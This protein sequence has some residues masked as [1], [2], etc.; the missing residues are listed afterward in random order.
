[1]SVMILELQANYEPAKE[2][3]AFSQV[4]S[5]RPI[6]QAKDKS[7]GFNRVLAKANQRSQQSAKSSFEQESSTQISKEQPFSSKAVQDPDSQPDSAGNTGHS[8]LSGKSDPL[9]D[10]EDAAKQSGLDQQEQ[11]ALNAAEGNLVLLA[12]MSQ[13]APGQNEQQVQ[14]GDTAVSVTAAA[15]Q[16]QP[17]VM[18]ADAA[19]SAEMPALQAETIQ[20]NLPAADAEAP[21]ETMQSEPA[22]VT[23][24][25]SLSSDPGTNSAAV[26]IP[27]TAA[28]DLVVQG[29]QPSL[30]DAQMP[31]QVHAAEVSEENQQA[32]QVLPQSSDNP[33]L[34][35]TPAAGNAQNPSG[36][37]QAAGILTGETAQ[38]TQQ[39]QLPPVTAVLQEAQPTSAAQLVQ[40]A[41][42]AKVQE[43]ETT[44]VK[45]DVPQSD[46]AVAVQPSVADSEAAASMNQPDPAAVNIPAAEGASREALDESAVVRM[47]IKEKAS[48][49]IKL[50]ESAAEPAGEEA[51]PAESQGKSVSKEDLRFKMMEKV[52]LNTSQK[53]SKDQPATDIRK[54]MASE[55]QRLTNT[56]TS[57]EQAV[58][59][60][61]S[62]SADTPAT[63][64][65]FEK[66]MFT[67]ARAEHTPPTVSTNAAAQ[68]V[69]AQEVIDQIVQK[70]ELL[71]SEN[72]N[73][74]MR[75]QLKPGFLGKM[76]IKIAI[77]DGLVTAKFVT[78]SQHVKQLLEANLV[79]LKQNLEAQGLKVD[80]TEVNV[81]LDNGGNF[82]GDE[83]GRELMWNEMRDGGNQNRSW[84][85]FEEYQQGVDTGLDKLPETILESQENYIQDG[86]VDFMI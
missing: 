24:V 80:R 61:T 37:E 12:Q 29:E 4:S 22:A 40:T 68:N 47:Q 75:I 36:A 2:A 25:F 1:M 35:N 76:L 20:I 86:R 19:V 59:T 65:G 11:P 81:Q 73:T 66:A 56:K 83:S 49:K 3:S 44:A 82:H 8:T 54:I 58:I 23:D 38:N 84:Q 46:P 10:R 62:I 52:I 53:T 21:R 18:L 72:N 27:S 45:K 17:E 48:L 13:A 69:D 34:P 57:G 85:R 5:S 74:E 31:V 26:T 55:S 60:D 42:D 6:S 43:P 67:A 14:A 77:E 30:P 64:T 63:G 79:T 28:K 39:N 32:L 41:A 9:T 33:T 71:K 16:P 50:S 70:A 7:G 51:E 15:N 78:E